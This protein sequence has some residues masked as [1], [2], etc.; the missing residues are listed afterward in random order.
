[1]TTIPLV[2][3]AF[4]SASAIGQDATLFE[5]P[6]STSPTSSSPAS[7]EFDLILR[8]PGS[9]E[10]LG[11]GTR[12]PTP[13]QWSWGE[14]NL[15]RLQRIP[16]TPLGLERVN[17]HRGLHGRSPIRT[18]FFDADSGPL[19]ERDLTGAAKN[20]ET[21]TSP[22]TGSLPSGIDNST[23]KFFPPIRNQG[24]LNSC[25]QF[26]A[27]Y[28]TLTHMTAMAR[29]WDAKSGGDAY[30]LSPKWT[31]NMVNGGANV[32][33]WHYD[34]YAIAQKHGIATWAE[35]PYDANY[36]AWCL[37]PTTWWNAIHLR[38]DQA[39]KVT[40]L[41]GSTGLNQLKQLLVNGY[42]LNFATYINSWVWGTV[43]NDPATPA[44]DAL[45]GKPCVKL[46]SGT[47]G[48]HSMTIVG[49]ND[50]VWVDHNANGVVDAGEKGALR[51]ANSWGTGWNEA[52]FCWVSYKALVTRNASATGEGLAWYDEATWVTARPS[53][54]PRLVAQF[55][56]THAKR[57][58]FAASLG[59]SATDLSA[60]ATVW[61]PY[62]VLAGSGGA[63]AFD[64]TTTPIS[65]TFYFDFTDLAPMTAGSKRFHLGLRDATSGDPLAFSNFTLVDTIHGKTITA[66]NPPASIDL[67]QY[68]AGVDY[69]VVA[70]AIAPEAVLF[71]SVTSGN[72]PLVVDFDASDSVDP[73]GTIIAVNWDF[74]DGTYGTGFTTQHT[75]NQAGT[76]TA[77]VT[78]TDNDGGQATSAVIITAIDPNILLAPTALTATA[79]SR[80]VTL[81]WSDN[82]TNESGYTIERGIKPK[83]GA[84]AYAVVGTTAANTSRFSQAVAAGTYLYRVR[85]IQA[86]TGKVSDY[87]NAYSIRVR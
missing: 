36:R 54:T 46:V 14:A 28:Y 43:A 33:S 48:G 4:A 40:G 53:Y 2:V 1:M 5:S 13:D 70:G 9:G 26:S 62:R 37:N 49:Y 15:E 86:S 67:N 69:D 44:D 39:G 35:F 58:Q 18:L 52:G 72:L 50:D 61:S 82:A 55:T 7:E 77:K 8:D 56:V 22:S 47:S 31:Y 60:P 59:L 23:L 32:G 63:Y 78:V 73:D 12:R 68:Y 76:F 16:I 79:A 19:S 51:V 83:S 64:G 38:A 11:T 75:Y 24:S 34:A 45:A 10:E 42:V 65:G 29:N 41:N 66:P 87:S 84:V 85:A 3:A 20:T 57:S 71:V 27:V 6:R 81:T 80:T 25:A 74:G 17:A 30:R 21:T